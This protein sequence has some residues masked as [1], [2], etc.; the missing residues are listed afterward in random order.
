MLAAGLGTLHEASPASA[1]TTSLIRTLTYNVNNGAPTPGKS[2]TNREPYVVAIVRRNSPG[3]FGLQELRH[4]RVDSNNVPMDD[5]VKTA[6]EN[7]R[8]VSMTTTP[9]CRLS[10][11]PIQRSTMQMQTTDRI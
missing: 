11:V 5:Y 3:I 4:D 10:S 8:P 6:F 7:P 9:S 1:T 2:W